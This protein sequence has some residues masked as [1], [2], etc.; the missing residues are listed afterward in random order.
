MVTFPLFPET[1]G[2]KDVEGV[3][4]LT[5][6]QDDNPSDGAEDLDV[7]DDDDDQLSDDVFETRSEAEERRR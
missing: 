1:P 7:D 5:E 2:D 4:Q 3:K 6:E